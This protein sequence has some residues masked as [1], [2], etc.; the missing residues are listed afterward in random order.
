MTE[1]SVPV[2]AATELR[3]QSQGPSD[4]LAENKPYDQETPWMEA[5]LGSVPASDRTPAQR[6]GDQG[7]P[8]RAGVLEADE[9][10]TGQAPSS[11]DMSSATGADRHGPVGVPA[12]APR[13]GPY[14]G[15]QSTPPVAPPSTEAGQAEASPATAS[16]PPP[17]RHGGGPKTPEGKVKVAQNA[18]RHGGWARSTSAVRRGPFREDPSAVHQFEKEVVR[19]LGPRNLVEKEAAWA[20]ARALS[21]Q[22]R[23]HTYVPYWVSL[24]TGL[25]RVPP[26]LLPHPYLGGNPAHDDS[27][28]VLDQLVSDDQFL[29]TTDLAEVANDL[30]HVSWADIGYML[31]SRLEPAN[32][33]LAEGAK[34]PSA[35]QWPDLIEKSL[36]SHFTAPPEAKAWVR[37]LMRESGVSLVLQVAV[38]VAAE[39]AI[40]ALDEAART[41]E[42]IA[43][44]V[45]AAYRFF[46]L[47]R[48]TLEPIKPK[49][50]KKKG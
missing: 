10:G 4:P 50:P 29:S 12:S 7:G 18:L 30:P 9:P 34:E 21:C 41:G 46:L 13:T 5:F 20:V 42:R 33:L 45:A 37:K 32:P 36:R 44:Q 23:F 11:D 1:P 8:A 19:Q 48:G 28:I 3:P 27:L 38:E 25:T 22:R 2:A 15:Q 6:P 24:R 47:V 43:G 35:R 49:G 31:L 16:G 17:K 40:K 14:R 39:Q 26:E